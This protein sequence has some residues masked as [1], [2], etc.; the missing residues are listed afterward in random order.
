MAEAARGRICILHWAALD[1]GSAGSG[2]ERWGREFRVAS[3]AHWRDRPLRL[4]RPW[5]WRVEVLELGS[6]SSNPSPVVA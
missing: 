1:P 2:R 5:G 4:G 3:V 6:L